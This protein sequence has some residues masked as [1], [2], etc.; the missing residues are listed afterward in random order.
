MKDFSNSPVKPLRKHLRKHPLSEHEIFFC[1]TN[2]FI[3][4]IIDDKS[5]RHKAAVKF[6]RKLSNAKITLAFS[7]IVFHEVWNAIMITE[8][9]QAIFEK[10]IHKAIK[11]KPQLL[12]PHF[13]SIK[14]NYSVFLSL[15][16]ALGGYKAFMNPTPEIMIKAL[17]CQEKYLLDISDSIH[18]ATFLDGKLNNFV[19]F[20]KDIREL[21]GLEFNIWCRYDQY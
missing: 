17:E 5:F 18:L 7:T 19:S 21:E 12:R 14:N 16:D 10:N 2:F 20:D 9:S 6:L 13:P 4:A 11:E 8:L 1:D 3:A 15:I